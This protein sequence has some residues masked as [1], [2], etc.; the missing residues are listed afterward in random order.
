VTD[1]QPRAIAEMRVASSR[2]R[3]ARNALPMPTPLSV[4]GVGLAGHIVE[5]HL[6][7]P[8]RPAEHPAFPGSSAVIPFADVGLQVYLR[9][10]ADNVN[11]VLVLDLGENVD[12]ARIEL[13]GN[14]LLPPV[15]DSSG[16]VFNF[17][18]PRAVAIAVSEESSETADLHRRL[19]RGTFYG[20]VVDGWRRRWVSQ[21][22]RALWAWTPI[23]LGPCFGRHLVL[24]FDRLPS[25]PPL[26]D[27][28]PSWGIDLQ[29]IVFYPFF[30]DVD[31][32]PHVEHSVVSS[33]V[34]RFDSASTFWSQHAV[35]APAPDT[36]QSVLFDATHHAVLLPSAL[37]GVPLADSMAGEVQMYGSDPLP[38]DPANPSRVFVVTEATADEVPLLDGVHLVFRPPELKKLY[39]GPKLP[40]QP[41]YLVRVHV[42]NDREAAFSPDGDHPAWRLAAEERLVEPDKRNDELITFAEPVLARWVRLTARP[43]PPEGAPNDI[44]LPF[45]LHRLD[46]V[47]CRSW[48]I[49]PELDGDLEISTV[50]IRLRG[51]SLLDDYAFIDGDHGLGVT[52]E[53]RQDGGA[54]SKIRSFRTLLTLIE[55]TQNRVYANSRRPDKPVQRYEEESSARTRIDSIGGQHVEGASEAR[56]EPEYGNATSTRGGTVTDYVDRPRNNLGATEFA[57]LPAQ[58]ATGLDTTRSYDVDLDAIAPPSIDFT[59]MTPEGIVGEFVHWGEELA[60]QG[61]PISVGV[62][63]N[64]SGNLGVSLGGQAGGSAGVSA[65]VGTSIG[66]GVTHSTVS[67]NQGSVVRSE[68]RTLSSIQKQATVSDTETESWQNTRSEDSREVTRRDL[69]TEVRRRGVE[70]RQGGVYEDLILVTVPVGLRL[71][72]GWERPVSAMLMGGPPPKALDCL[73][74]RVEHLPPGVRMD[75]EF[76][77][78]SIPKERRS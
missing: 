63:G 35:A 70:V 76:R 10:N 32:A 44:A 6:G 4:T 29:R 26:P 8:Q 37:S 67:G 77:G 30:E 14:P 50:M 42:T 64:L 25:L 13:Y 20:D 53:V 71:R 18:V 57:S 78:R 40:F 43:V 22:V 24:G 75:V 62:G 9:L 49:T 11:V 15:D 41:N 17:G 33:R 60:A 23:H 36:H 5:Y 48:Q 12:L 39:Q 7:A 66:G 28:A 61:L 1:A 73:R 72:G 34:E 45:L 55:E 19:N 69:S 21:D 58:D 2:T 65:N 52:V 51:E 38:L 59:S 3:T 54:F 56:V 74:V 27:G 68:V 47:R 31:H 16:P 46:L